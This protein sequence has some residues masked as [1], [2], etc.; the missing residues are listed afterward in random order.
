L[1]TPVVPKAVASLP[2]LSLPFAQVPMPKSEASLDLSSSSSE[3]SYDSD[4]DF[5]LAQKE[6]DESLE[7]LQQLVSVVLLPFFGKWLGRRW[8]QWGT[9]SATAIREYPTQITFQLS[10]AIC[11]SDWGSH[12]FWAH[13]HYDETTTYVIA[14]I[15]Y[16]AT[17]PLRNTQ[18]DPFASY[19]LP[20][21]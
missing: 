2:P 20:A 15:G 16:I 19:G 10:R 6:W 13:K 14:R 12:S 1:Q 11:D 5:R 3:D 9:S 4:D 21:F 7:Q 17:S 8:S 18:Q